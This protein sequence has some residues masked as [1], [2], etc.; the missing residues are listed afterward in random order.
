MTQ[1]R[2]R[3]KVGPAIIEASSS[4]G[5]G[6]MAS[7]YMAKLSVNGALHRVAVK[8][9]NIIDPGEKSDTAT[10]QGV[11]HSAIIA[12]GELLSRLHHP[13]IV[14][15]FPLPG[16]G[17]RRQD[18]V[19]RELSLLGRPWYFIME[20]LAGGSLAQKLKRHKW[21]PLPLAAEVVYQ[22]SQALEYCHERSIYH[23]D[24]KPSNIMF[25][26]PWEPDDATWPDVVL[27][28]FG[29]AQAT[30]EE[31]ME[32]GAYH[33]MAPE[34]IDSHTAVVSEMSSAADIY[35]L[36]VCFYEM[37]AGRLPFDSHSD[38]K[39]K[40]AVLSAK[41]PRIERL[42]SGES[43]PGE[44]DT[45]IQRMLSKDPA[46]RPTA[47]EVATTL[48]RWAP[49]P[50]AG[51]KRTNAPGQRPRL[52]TVGSRTGGVG[53]RVAAIALAVVCLLEAGGLYWATRPSPIPDPQTPQV[54][55]G[56]SETPVKWD[57]PTIPPANPADLATNTAAPENEP[58]ADVKTRTPTPRRSTATSTRRATDRPAA[59]PAPTQ[60]SMVATSTPL[61]TSTPV[62]TATLTP[63]PAAT[64]TPD[65][66]D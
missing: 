46:A 29:I 43:L 45:L 24:M 51:G 44:L 19:A 28:D 62:P 65:S 4:A 42:A 7:V 2:P 49:Q 40:S 38:Q 36:G 5:R 63:V 66:G 55:V 54:V 58:A 27:A 59:T 32:A 52:D 30:G 11:F 34:R 57:T 33:Y 25:R 50:R 41:P 20:Y 53:W 35:G 13:G 1:L 14:R 23:L 48:N 15:I 61:P 3:T 37:L 6:G 17:V 10:L 22:V 9:S 39:L 16:D 56:S 21:L 60:T 12:E 47:S 18:H 8:L 31:T 64:L 26:F